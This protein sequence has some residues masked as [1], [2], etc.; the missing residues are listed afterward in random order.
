M[1]VPARLRRVTIAISVKVGEG[2]V[3]AADSTTSMFEKI[4]GVSVLSQSFHHAQKLIQIRDLPIGVLTYGLALIGTRNIE[5]LVAEFQAEVLQDEDVAEHDVRKVAEKLLT[6]IADKYDQEE[7]PPTPDPDGVVPPDERTELG[8]VVGGY[9]KHKFQPEEYSIL[10]PSR[11]LTE[12]PVM[13][14]GVLWWGQVQALYR[15]LLGFDPR[16]SKWLADKGVDPND[17]PGVI[18]ELT[19][20]F[21]WRI[22]F[23]AMPLQD[24][25]DLAVFLANVAIGHSRFVT[26]PPVCGGQV[27]VATISHRGFEWV[28]RKNF[29]V[30]S[31]SIFF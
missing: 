5:S 6:F 21:G 13:A 16:M 24:A 17:V 4:S 28:R 22:Q 23:D 11:D 10:L 29:Q 3:Y 9:S 8:I 1:R 7:P 2:L 30:K 12:R 14:N 18:Q 31:D 25:I 26:G 20:E 27:D 15:I 19:S